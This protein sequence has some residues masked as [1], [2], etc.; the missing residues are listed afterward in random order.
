MAQSTDA[1]LAASNAA[2]RTV[3]EAVLEEDGEKLATVFTEN[4]ALIAPDGRRVQG[5]TTIRASA[6]LLFLTLGG[7]ELNRT[8]LTMNM[9]DGVA[10]ETGSY[11]FFKDP[12]DKQASAIKGKY[13]VVW[14]QEQN[15]WKIA[16]AIG[17]L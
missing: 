2:G 11:E 7:G 12:G 14:K 16:V 9:V 3:R 4:A 13:V 8:R 6:T 15:L 10:Y 17:L 1:V 5:R